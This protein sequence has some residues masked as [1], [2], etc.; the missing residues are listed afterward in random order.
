MSR[1][2]TFH[3]SV[4]GSTLL[5]TAVSAAEPAVISSPARSSSSIINTTRAAEPVD[6]GS[7]SVIDSLLNSDTESDSDDDERAAAEPR[8]AQSVSPPVVSQPLVSQPAVS[9]SVASESPASLQSVAEMAAVHG[10]QA[11]VRA[12]K[13]RSKQERALRQL[14]SHN[15]P[16]RTEQSSEQQHAAYYALAV[17]VG[18]LINEPRTYKEVLRSPHRVQ[19]ERAMQEELDSIKANNTYS[20]VPLPAGR[21]AIGCKFSIR[22]RL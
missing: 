3:E 18:Q 19:W 20:L 22:V 15:S 1:D 5:T 14:A 16:G 4:A 8:Q 9:L 6:A 7:L 17:H 21:Q 10:V 13:P 11:A 2:V 12:R